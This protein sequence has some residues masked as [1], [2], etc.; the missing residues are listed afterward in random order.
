MSV[1][2]DFIT[3]VWVL[4]IT[5]TDV[6]SESINYAVVFFISLISAMLLYVFSL[7]KTMVI[8]KKLILVLVLF[9]NNI[10]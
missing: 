10:H 5:C 6:P 8:G 7:V 3:F 2:L 9:K 4:M 1:D